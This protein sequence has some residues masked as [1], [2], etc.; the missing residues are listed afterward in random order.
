M[1]TNKQTNKQTNTQPEMFV[2]FYKVAIWD[3]VSLR[4]PTMTFN[5]VKIKRKKTFRRYHR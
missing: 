3:F 4:L 5:N 2:L 1:Q